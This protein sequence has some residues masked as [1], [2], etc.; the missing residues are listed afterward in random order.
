IR[1][2]IKKFLECGFYVSYRFDLTSNAQRRQ[3]LL[4]PKDGQDIRT[5]EPLSSFD[6]RYMWNFNLYKQLRS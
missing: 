5:V 3:K 1:E 2:G 6:E 4:Q